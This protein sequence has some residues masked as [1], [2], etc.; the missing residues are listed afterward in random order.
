AGDCQEHIEMDEDRPGEESLT[1]PPCPMQSNVDDHTWTSKNFA[2]VG[3]QWEDHI[4]GEHCYTKREHHA[5]YQILLTLMRLKLNLLIE[6][7]AIR[8]CIS[9]SQV[10]R[11]IRPANMYAFCVP[12]T[13]FDLKVRWYDLSLYTT[14]KPGESSVHA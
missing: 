7:L 12:G 8:F 6:D 11:I 3:T 5:T 9:V 1:S 13:H 14:Q 4:F 10:S 2:S